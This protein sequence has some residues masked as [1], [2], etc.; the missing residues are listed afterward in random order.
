MAEVELL[1]DPS[2]S[3]VKFEREIADYRK[4][5]GE[6]INKGWWMVSCEFPEVFVVFATAQLNPPAVVFGTV[7]DFTNYDLWPPSV[8]LVDPFTR[9]P[10]KYKQLPSPLLRGI[11]A[12]TQPDSMGQGLVAVTPQ[13]LMVAHGEDEVPFLCLPGVR[14]YHEHPAHTGD[15]WLL[16]RGRGEGTLFFLLNH[17]YRYGVEPIKSYQIQIRAVQASIGGFVL[18]GEFPE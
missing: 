2:V 3:R 12:S 1:V 18:S 17:I 14:E 6:L 11:R 8:R 13:P 9:L 5:Q 4:I 15:S 7:L 16:H 10:Y